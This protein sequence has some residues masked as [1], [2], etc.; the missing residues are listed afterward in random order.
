VAAGRRRS[1]SLHGLGA[2]V[3]TL[4]ALP[5]FL[6]IAVQHARAQQTQGQPQPGPQPKPSARELARDAEEK[7]DEAQEDVDRWMRGHVPRPMQRR[8]PKELLRWQ[9]VALPLLA[10]FALALGAL[11][12]R[13]TRRGLLAIAERTAAS[14]DHVLIKRVGGPLTLTWAVLLMYLALPWLGLREHAYD[15]VSNGLQ[16]VL[17]AAFFWMCARSVDVGAELLLSSPWGRSRRSAHSLVP[18][19]S[20]VT[21]LVVLALA[22]VALLSELGY[23]VAS[24]LAG[25]GIG[26]VALALAAQKTVENLFG[27]F[28]IAADRPFSEGDTVKLDDVT[29]T[30]EDIGLRSTRIRTADR[31]LITVPNGRLADMRIESLTARDRMRLS[32]VL[33]LVYETTSQQLRGVLAG[34]EHVL[35]VHPKIWPDGLSVRFVALGASSLDIEINAWFK[36]TDADEFAQ[37]RQ[38]LLLRFMEV[39]EASN[40]RFAF[41]T[42]TVHVVNHDEP[43]PR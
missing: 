41:P 37:C 25:L 42:R 19:A 40:T 9:W 23:P 13:I 33:G 29:G 26:G 38:E 10:L 36:T 4:I 15:W 2:L 20:R 3:L 1:Q 16:G 39:V 18:L 30:V 27:T 17:L 7:V 32:C 34:L 5:P 8:G 6:P 11:L 14:W 31:T 28:S 21:K 43:V 35:R 24:L 22:V 12:A